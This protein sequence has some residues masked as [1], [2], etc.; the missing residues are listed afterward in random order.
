MRL[1][2]RQQSFGPTA[3][4]AGKI[5][6]QETRGLIRKQHRRLVML[7]NANAVMGTGIDALSTLRATFEKEMFI[8]RTWRA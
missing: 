1:V 4:D 2:N 3:L 7:M 5:I 6:A 8:N